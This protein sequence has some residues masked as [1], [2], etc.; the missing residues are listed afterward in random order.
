[1]GGKRHGWTAVSRRDGEEEQLEGKSD[2]E[3]PDPTRSVGVTLKGA[4][5]SE[6][7]DKTLV[8][9]R[10]ADVVIS[11]KQANGFMAFFSKPYLI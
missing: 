7:R 9:D 3:N 6:Q 2:R 5:E 4:E 10:E 11:S 8:R 1:M